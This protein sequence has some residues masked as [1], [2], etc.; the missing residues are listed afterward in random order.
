MH[1]QAVA[2]IMPILLINIF[3]HSL[4]L[5]W[6]DDPTHSYSLS[7]YYIFFWKIRSRHVFSYGCDVLPSIRFSITIWLALAIVWTRSRFCKK[8]NIIQPSWVTAL[9]ATANLRKWRHFRS[10]P[11]DVKTMASNNNIGVH[12]ICHGVWAN[13]MWNALS[14]TLSIQEEPDKR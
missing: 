2:T 12:T 11:N 6:V 14:A 10:H 4:T 5:P 3:F 8:R 9:Y 1:S 13:K 7:Y